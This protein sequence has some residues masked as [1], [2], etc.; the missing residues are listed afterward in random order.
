MKQLYLIN[1]IRPNQRYQ[2][3]DVDRE[4]VELVL[5]RVSEGADRPLFRV[6]V[7]KPK[8]RKLG[9]KLVQVEE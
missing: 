7:D 4:N 1:I 9:Y 6:P 5:K 3:I 8:L 2:V